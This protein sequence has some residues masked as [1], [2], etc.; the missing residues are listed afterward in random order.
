[1]KTINKEV[2]KIAYEV[3]DS[4]YKEDPIR[5]IGVRLANLTNNKTEQVSIFNI[6]EGKEED[7]IQNT[8]DNINNK[9]GNSVIKPA[10]LK[11]VG[12]S[13]RRIDKR[14]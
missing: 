5:L 3:F 14:L 4:N 11:V 7:S 1:M 12:E 8:I 10:S 13:R 9:F 6:E 2:L